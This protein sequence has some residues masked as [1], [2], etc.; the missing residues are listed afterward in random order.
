MD[1]TGFVRTHELRREGNL[2]RGRLAVDVGPLQYVCELTA[3]TTG[4]ADLQRL[5]HEYLPLY[6]GR[7]HGDPSRPWNHFS[8]NLRQADGTPR[9]DYQGNWRDIFQNWEA[10]ALSFPGYLGSMIFRFLNGSTADGF[11]PYRVTRDGFEWEVPE[12]DDPW[13]N[14]GY[15]GDHQIIYLLKLLELSSRFHPER[16]TSSLNRPIFSYANVPYRIKPFESLLEDAKSAGLIGL[17]RDEKSR[18]YIVKS[19]AS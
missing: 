1:E 18:G 6:F 17:E 9:L 16:L 15:W 11:N 2:L 14:I 3:R 7:R 19:A 10:L 12:P 8:I 13:S 4:D 5:S